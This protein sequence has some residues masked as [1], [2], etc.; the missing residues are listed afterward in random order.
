MA[1]H[2]PSERVVHRSNSVLAIEE[3]AR[4]GMGLAL[5]PCF[6][7]ER[8]PGLVRLSDTIPEAMTPIW[9]L[10]H[11]D[12]RRVARVRVF[13]D[14]MAEAIGRNRAALDLKKA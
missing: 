14:F 12:L 7:G 9:L 11:R 5:P 3:A 6:Q 8:A 13:L 10:T 1:A 4:A 2:I